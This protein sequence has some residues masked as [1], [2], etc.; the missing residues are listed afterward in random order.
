VE[1]EGP[2]IRRV[3]GGYRVVLTPP[4]MELLRTLASRLRS[5]IEAGG[6]ETLRLYPPAFP[7]DPEAEASYREVARDDLVSGREQRLRVF[8]ATLGQERLDPRQ[9]EAWLG[10]LADARLVVG[11]AL[12]VTDEDDPT[13]WSPR[14]PDAADRLAY[15]YAAYLEEQLV[16]AL[17]SALPD[18]G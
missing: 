3:A 1:V 9:A 16:A 7:D 8:E 2:H 11:T 17:A 5:A 4:E 13:D 18:A 10:V 14:D 12:A 15:L 6:P